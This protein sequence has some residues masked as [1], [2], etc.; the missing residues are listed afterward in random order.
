MRPAALCHGDVCRK[1]A[2][3]GKAARTA[4]LD[5]EIGRLGRPSSSAMTGAC[6]PLGWS[7][8]ATGGGVSGTF[9]LPSWQAN[10][11][12]PTASGFAGRGLPDVAGDAD[13]NTGYQIRVDGSSI[14]V[15]GTSAVAPLWGGLVALLS[16]GMGKPV[17][18]L[19]PNLYQT[20]AEESGTFND[21]TSGNNGDFSAGPGWDQ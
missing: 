1:D 3:S 6:G 21:I 9:A 11:S 14:M 7:R 19:N 2:A 8:G 18:Y 15:G 17:V 20:I 16:Q 5:P 4:A 12:V 13:P 10:I